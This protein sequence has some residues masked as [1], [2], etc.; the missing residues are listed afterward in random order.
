MNKRRILKGIG[1][2]LGLGLVLVGLLAAVFIGPRN[3]IG[4][5]RYDTR[6]QGALRVGDRAPDVELVVPQELADSAPRVHL[7]DRLK[8]RPLVLVFGSFT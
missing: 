2:A 3:V 1:L 4:M 7:R 6:R 8:G 5:L